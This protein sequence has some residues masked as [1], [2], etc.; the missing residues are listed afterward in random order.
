MP[1]TFSPTLLFQLITDQTDEMINVHDDEGNYIYVSPAMLRLTGYAETDLI[2]KHG[3]DFCHPDDR[4]STRAKIAEMLLTHSSKRIQYR[5]LHRDG[6]YY[7]MESHIAQV[8]TSEGEPIRF[9]SLVRDITRSMEAEA[10]LRHREAQYL[11][12]LDS[13]PDVVCRINREGRMLFV[14][15]SLEREIGTATENVVGRTLAEVTQSPEILQ[16]WTDGIA[17]VFRTGQVYKLDFSRETPQGE[18]VYHTRLVPEKNG[19]NVENVLSI[20]EDVTSSRLALSQKMLMERRLQE[21][22]RM[23]SLG[24]LAG[25]IAHDFNNLLMS[26]MGYTE[27]VVN[28]LPPDNPLQEH[29]EQ[30][31]I[32]A[33]RAADLTKQMLAFAGK[34]KPAFRPIDLNSLV[35]EISKLLRISISKNITFETALGEN[36]PLLDGEATQLRQVVMN[37]VINAS[38]A[39]AGEPGHIVLSTGLETLTAQDLLTMRVGAQLLP[40]KYLFL[41]VSDTGAGMSEETQTR[42]FEPFFTTKFTGRGLGLAAV[43]GIVEEHHG[44]L[45]VES[46]IGEGTAFRLFLPLSEM[47]REEVVIEEK[48]PQARG[49]HILLVDDDKSVRDVANIMLTS[50]GYLVTEASGVL[51]AVRLLESEKGAFD[52]LLLDYLMPEGGGTEVAAKANL[53]VPDLPVLMMSGYSGSENF[54]DAKAQKEAIFLH[55]PFT[56]ASLIKSVEERVLRVK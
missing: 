5:R 45:R 53:L 36:L 14:T 40:G 52:L 29:L 6:N 41:K 26:M 25:G 37:L 30:V 31:R 35:E 1:E 24:V 2:G 33:R 28:A 46:R 43:V 20:T 4:V 7:W 13:L 18:R 50:K 44:A 56:L 16:K 48:A 15:S 11:H 21:G 3:F 54:P 17:S 8:P 51:E 19:E 38:E 12:L 39:M 10:S 23:E 27:L 42:I 34:R 9:M 49:G 22:Q 32:A 47:E 55:K